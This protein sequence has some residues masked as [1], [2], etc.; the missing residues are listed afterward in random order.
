[1]TDETGIVGEALAETIRDNI[2]DLMQRHPRHTFLVLTKNPAGLAGEWPENAHVGTSVTRTSECRRVDILMQRVRAG[3]RWV[4]VE[5]LLESEFDP[6]AME[7][8]GLLGW[9]VVGAQTGT[10]AGEP[11]LDATWRVVEWGR[12]R[13]VP[14][15]VKHNMR[16]WDESKDWPQEFPEVVPYRETLSLFG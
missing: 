7:Q 14:V 9:V 8:H 10:G 11:Q 1:L 16:C 6:S 12:A 3:V 13:G 5:P 15:F 2:R 4:S